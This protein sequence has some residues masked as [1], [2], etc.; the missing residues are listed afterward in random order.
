MYSSVFSDFQYVLYHKASN[1][2]L[3]WK[4][5]RL[6][7]IDCESWQEDTTLVLNQSL[8]SRFEVVQNLETGALKALHGGGNGPVADW[9]ETELKWLV[10]DSLTTS[11]QYHGG[12]NY[13]DPRDGSLYRIGGYGYYTMKNHVQRFDPETKTWLVLPVKSLT[14]ELFYPRQPA[15]VTA[16]NRPGEVLIFWGHG[17]KTGEQQRLFHWLND[18]WVL[19]LDSLTLE[20]KWDAGDWIPKTR[21][22]SVEIIPERNEMYYAYSDV[23]AENSAVKLFTTGLDQPDFQEVGNDLN[24]SDLLRIL[25]SGFNLFYLE[26]TNE[27]AMLQIKPLDENQS[28]EFTVY[29]LALPILSHDEFLASAYGPSFI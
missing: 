18:L 22:I 10:D 28:V 25:R 29:T 17:N 14:G 5:G 9:K 20:K 16:G 26:N 27:L 8:P 2:L 7:K 12:G 3:V 24:V 19:N 1:A 21:M 23:I 13:I 11:E 6:K 4:K 15:R